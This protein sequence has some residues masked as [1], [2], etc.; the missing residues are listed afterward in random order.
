MDKEK[1][2]RDALRERILCELRRAGQPVTDAR[3]L[4]LIDSTRNTANWDLAALEPALS[5]DAVRSIIEELQ[6][7]Y[8]VKTAT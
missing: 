6:H 8:D 3:I 2:S 7:R 5:T 4:V 1:L